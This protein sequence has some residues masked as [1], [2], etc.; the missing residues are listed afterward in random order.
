[1]QVVL[2]VFL[3]ITTPEGTLINCQAIMGEIMAFFRYP[4][5]QVSGNRL[6]TAISGCVF[7]FSVLHPSYTWVPTLLNIAST[8]RRVA[9]ISRFVNWALIT[10]LINVIPPPNQF[11][12]RAFV[13]GVSIAVAIDTYW[14]LIFFGYLNAKNE[15]K[16]T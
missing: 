16:K 7:I 9:L 2:F 6:L 1:M 15:I 8:G 4:I 12:Y 11:I 14:G 3:C 10:V 13:I 5:L